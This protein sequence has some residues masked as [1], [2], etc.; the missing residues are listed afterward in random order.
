MKDR[1][2][3]D[4]FVKAKSNINSRKRPQK[5]GKE[6]NKEAFFKKSEDLCF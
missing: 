3:G 2:I 5:R 4:L 1:E 6:I